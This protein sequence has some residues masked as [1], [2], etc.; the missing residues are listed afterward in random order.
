MVE[1]YD[2]EALSFTYGSRV[3]MCGARRPGTETI[4]LGGR[5]PRIAG[6]LCGAL[7]DWTRT[8]RARGN[9]WLRPLRYRRKC[10]RMVRRLVYRRLLPSI[11]G[12]KSPRTNRTSRQR[13]RWSKIHRAGSAC[14]S[15]RILASFYEGF[16]MRR[17]LKH[18][19]GIPV[20][21]LRISYCLRCLRLTKEITNLGNPARI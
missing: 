2:P 13:A 14:V 21:G 16:A 11:A 12:A 19:S 4:S 10:P 18:S 9:E 8:S 7:E 1:P 17:T 20:C 3:G 15:R 6:K 5:A